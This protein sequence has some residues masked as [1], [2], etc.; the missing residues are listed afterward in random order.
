MMNADECHMMC[1][2]FET[3]PAIDRQNQLTKKSNA[4]RNTLKGSKRILM[5]GEVEGLQVDRAASKNREANE[6]RN[7]LEADLSSRTFLFSFQHFFFGFH[8]ANSARQK[9][10]KR[11]A[12]HSHTRSRRCLY[13]R[14]DKEFALTL[15]VILLEHCWT[16]VENPNRSRRP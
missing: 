3:I 6:L 9:A 4:I 11:C 2:L 12:A 13:D 7:E 16:C 10:R 15:M 5:V 8:K 14:P 1:H